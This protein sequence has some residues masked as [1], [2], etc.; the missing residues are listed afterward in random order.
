VKAEP[1]KFDRFSDSLQGKGRANPV[2]PLW[3]KEI[4]GSWLGEEHCHER[5]EAWIRA[6]LVRQI[7]HFDGLKKV[8]DFRAER[9]L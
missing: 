4:N 2:S 1:E 8:L 3:T 6:R 5:G 9:Q 7:G